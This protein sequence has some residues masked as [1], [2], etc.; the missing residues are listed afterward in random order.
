MKNKV[1][2]QVFSI[3]KQRNDGL[4]DALEILSEIGYDGVEL[5]RVNTEGLSLPDFKKKLEG[6]NLK[7]VSTMGKAEPDVFEFANGLGMQYIVG[8][9]NDKAR[10]ED[11]LKQSADE[12]NEAGRKCAAAGLKYAVH[13]HS[14][15][16]GKVAGD[17]SGKTAYE[18]ILEHTDPALV[19]MELDVGWAALAGIDVIALVKKYPGR[20]P[21]IHVKECDRVAKTEEELE[22]F[23]ERALKM[24]PPQF[25]NGSPVFKPEQEAIFYNARNWNNSLGKGIVDWKGLVSECEK[26]GTL[27]YISERE[28]HHIG[29]CDGD[30]KCCAIEDY[31]YLRAL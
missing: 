23:P 5:L 2:A 11:E 18:F 1:F 4:L 30:V 15:E 12:L 17:A 6:L 19:G 21:L 31:N 26:Q 24:G 7:V 22:H 9:G 27:A 25:I 28:Y 14:Q 13:N 10:T 3:N 29:D 16:F 20:F 8:G